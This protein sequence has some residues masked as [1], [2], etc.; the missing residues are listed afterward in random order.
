MKLKPRVLPSDFTEAFPH[1]ILLLRNTSEVQLVSCILQHCQKKGHWCR[2]TANDL[3]LIWIFPITSEVLMPMLEALREDY[4]VLNLYE[5][6]SFEVN[7]KFIRMFAIMI[8]D[9][10][11][12]PKYAGEIGDAI[13]A[14]HLV[15]MS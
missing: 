14:A 6:K 4:G 15:P 11:N 8:N 12:R 7:E 3:A 13:N 9:K 1:R 5:P 2:F 10:D